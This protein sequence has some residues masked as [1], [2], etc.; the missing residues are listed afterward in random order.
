MNIIIPLTGEIREGD[1]VEV[2]RTQAWDSHLGW[3]LEQWH[4]AAAA[5]VAAVGAVAIWQLRKKN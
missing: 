1:S 4:Y 2:S 3:Q 5:A